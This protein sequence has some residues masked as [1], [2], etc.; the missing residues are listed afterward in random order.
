MKE[1]RKRNKQYFSM[2]TAKAEKIKSIVSESYP[3]FFKQ[4]TDIK[5]LLLEKEFQEKFME[6]N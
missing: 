3:I 6:F 1:T 4:G 5:P 2:V